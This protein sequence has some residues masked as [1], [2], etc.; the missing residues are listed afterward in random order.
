MLQMS[1]M[2]ESMPQSPLRIGLFATLGLLLAGCYGM[3]PDEEP[4]TRAE[5]A[6]N[7]CGAASVAA[8]LVVDGIPAYAQCTASSS[9][10]IYSNNGVDTSTTAASSEWKRTQFSG[11][12]QCTELVHRYWLFKWNITWL[13]NGNAGTWCSSTPPSSSGIVQSTTPVHGDAIVFLPGSCGADTT[14]G[15]VALVDTVDT[16]GSKV[17]FVEQN[18]AGRRTSAWSCAACFLHVVANNGS[19]GAT[20]TGGTTSATGGAM[21]TTGGVATGGR[22]NAGGG[23]SAAAGGNPTG[24]GGSVTSTGGRATSGGSTTTATGGSSAL[25]SGGSLASGG[26]S[27]NNRG[28]QT[29]STGGV[30]PTGGVTNGNG[31]ANPAATGGTTTT[32]TT[33]VQS[34]GT[35]VGGTAVGGTA[36]GGTAVGG[37]SSFGAAGQ[38]TTSGDGIADPDS[39]CSCRMPHS[40]SSN[41]T[42]GFVGLAIAMLLRFRRQRNDA[43]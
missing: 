29:T 27:S 25:S 15:H 24:T 11:G 36:V 42:L 43:P 20:G 26:L 3:P 1:Q 13:P 39:G 21:S 10:A 30:A 37:D 22:A 17:T 19:A 28:G 35:A 40:N 6:V 2:S 33:A 7:V 9:S 8:N 31:G 14:Y 41:R 18:N 23:T 12:Y 5:Q 4:V 38:G 34:G 16:A 32:S